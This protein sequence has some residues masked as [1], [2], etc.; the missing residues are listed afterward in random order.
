MAAAG[1]R[2]TG[3]ATRHVLYRVLEL[4]LEIDMQVQRS[5]VAEGRLDLRGQV[6]PTDDNMSSV[7]GLVVELPLAAGSQQTVT[8]ALGE[9]H[10]EAPEDADVLVLHAHGYEI[11]VPVLRL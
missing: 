6:F 5:R 4:D 10:L 7:A 3:G 8:S 9:F 1:A 2:G 11:E